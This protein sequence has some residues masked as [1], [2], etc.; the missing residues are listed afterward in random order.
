MYLQH[1]SGFMVAQKDCIP[2]KSFSLFL[3]VATV[4]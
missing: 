1:F 4:E 2:C 3:G